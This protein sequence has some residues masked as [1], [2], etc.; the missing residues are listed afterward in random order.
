M[1]FSD[2][3]WLMQPGVT[4]FYP[5]EAHDVT[6]ENGTLLIHAPTRPIRHRGDTLGGPLLT[7]RL[8]SPMADVV[9]VHIEHYAGAAD[10]NPRIPLQPQKAPA[11]KIEN[12]SNEAVLRS[13]D[14]AVHVKKD[15]WEIAFEA[16]GR[17]LTRST[18]R[19]MGYV[20]Y[21]GRGTFVHERLH[22]GVG[23]CVY[24]LGERFT[25]FVKNGQVVE[26]ENRDGGTGSDQA[27]KC[28]PFYLTN[29]GYGVLV[30][31]T[32]PVSFE[33]ASERTARVQFS[34]P[35]E[36]LEYFLIYGPTPKDVLRKLT[37]LTGR[38]ALPPAWSFG[39]WLSTSF[40]TSYDEKTCT[41]FLDGMKSRGLPLHVFHFDCFWMREFDCSTRSAASSRTSLPN[42]AA[43]PF[44]PIPTAA[45][46]Q[47]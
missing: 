7:I 2:G 16:A 9:S 29:R 34:I 6:E 5:A 46:W 35:G 40:T 41:G 4:G 42:S 44:F 33:V 12:G 37:Q 24:G 30:H 8:G 15:G 28:V 10:H 31:E 3:E 21:A 45:R 36:K 39:L 23:E 38:P 19:G 13:G 43:K 11:V 18:G 1:K 47:Y 20:Q 32:G 27:Y 14:L 17:M 25:A 26:N 22:L